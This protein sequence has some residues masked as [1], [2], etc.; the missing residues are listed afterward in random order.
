MARSIL[1]RLSKRYGVSVEEI[2]RDMGEAVDEAFKNPQNQELRS[3]FN[4]V[5]P[6]LEEFIAY[7]GRRVRDEM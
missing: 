1:R 3:E 2:R 5:K 6:S 7:A 4:R